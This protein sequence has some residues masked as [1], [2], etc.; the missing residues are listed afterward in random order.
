MGCKLRRSCFIVATHETSSTMHA[1]CRSHLSTSPKI[2]LARKS[3]TPTSPYATRATTNHPTI[4]DT[5]HMK[6][7]LQLLTIPP[8]SPL[9]WAAFPGGFGNLYSATFPNG[10]GNFS[11]CIRQLIPVYSETSPMVFG[12]SCIR[13]TWIWQLNGWIRQLLSR[14]IRQLIFIRQ[15]I[16]V[17]SATSLGVYRNSSQCIR[18]LHRFYW[19]PLLYSGNLDLATE[20]T[21]G[22][23][24]QLPNPSCPNSG[25]LGN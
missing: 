22:F 15:L 13:A 9:Y 2:A 12:N 25:G 3:D 24:V 21:G 7:H 23:G 4:C 19:A 6:R 5:N 17:A 20:L 16:R 18:K 10:F 1:C 8:W 11:A 14:W